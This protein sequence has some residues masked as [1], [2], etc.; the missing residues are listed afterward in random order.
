M[1]RRTAALRRIRPQRWTPGLLGVC[2]FLLVAANPLSALPPGHHFEG[3]GP[4]DG[5]PHR[6]VYDIAVDPRGFLWLATQNGLARFDG[7]DLRVFRHD[8]A[9]P[10]SLPNDYIRTVAFDDNGVLWVGTNGGGLC[11]FDPHQETFETYLLTQDA[12]PQATRVNDITPAGPDHL[13]LMGLDGVRL[14]RPST[15]TFVDVPLTSSEMPLETDGSL[16]A[17]PF[18]QDHGAWY[19]APNHLYR[20]LPGQTPVLVFKFPDDFQAYAAFVD[21][22]NHIW[23]ASEKELVTYQVDTG[24]WRSRAHLDVDAVDL[25]RLGVRPMVPDARGNLWLGLLGIGL[26]RIDTAAENPEVTLIRQSETE[27]SLNHV[28][29]MV[30]D[31]SGILWFATYDDGLA[32]LDPTRQGAIFLKH[33]DSDPE[34]IGRYGIRATEVG[35]SGRIWLGHLGSGVDALDTQGKVDFRLSTTEPV[36]RRLSH[37]AIWSLHEDSAGRLWIGTENGMERYDPK[38]NLVERLHLDTGPLEERIHTIVEDATGQLYAG[39]LAEVYTW[40]P[41]HD[42]ASSLLSGND[43]DVETPVL[44]LEVDSQNNLWIGTDGNGLFRL[45]PTRTRLKHFPSRLTGPTQIQLDIVSAIHEDTR[46]VVWIATLGGG[47]LRYDADQDDFVPVSTDVPLLSTFLS[48]LLPTA[49]GAFWLPTHNGLNRFDPATGHVDTWDASDGLPTRGFTS[50]AST[51]DAHGMLFLGS[52]EGLFILPPNAFGVHASPPRPVLTRFNL[53][54]KPVKL[55][56]ME[57]E[58]PLQQATGSTESLT[59]RYNQ[60]PFSIEFSALHFANPGKNR[61]EYR[62]RGVDP[63]WVQASSDQRLAAY[64]HVPPGRY[65]FE[66]RATSRDGIQSERPAQLEIRILPPPWRTWWAYTL[67]TLA[68]ITAIAVFVRAQRHKVLREREINRQLDELVKLRTE[69]VNVLNGLLPICSCCKK[70]RDDEGYW[71]EVESYVEARSEAIFSHSLCPPCAR[72]LYPDL[73]LPA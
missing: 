57:P 31:Q 44:A 67:Y 63:E 48:D 27:P 1:S 26:A 8:A 69:Q 19:V 21:G 14:F 64:S 5:L 66:V 28:L 55:Q 32:K 39:A 45:D 54:N 56:R 24:Q 29:S 34:S 9:D 68:L 16:F 59:L 42:T 47:L 18:S 7:Y 53:F 17:D 33:L 36:A 49:D 15:A 73:E 72:T 6:T 25:L 58:S 62:L 10:Q 43:L 71:S 38:R 23:L 60:N 51:L 52:R 13:W 35:P 70:I 41:G 3:L 61:Y 12:E 65:R 11:R 2:W 50:K 37:D 30:E 20:L 4:E 46:G 22:P 40:L